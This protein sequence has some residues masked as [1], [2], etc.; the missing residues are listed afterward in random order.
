MSERSIVQNPPGR[1]R[2]ASTTLTPSRKPNVLPFL[3]EQIKAKSRPW[4]EFP[5]DEVNAVPV[6]VRSKLPDR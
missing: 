6:I 2:V 1:S 3:A 5:D 4:P